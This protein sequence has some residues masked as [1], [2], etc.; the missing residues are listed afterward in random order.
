MSHK[1]ATLFPGWLKN[2]KTD[3]KNI[4][5]FI[6]HDFLLPNCFWLVFQTRYRVTSKLNNLFLFLTDFMSPSTKSLKNS[7]TRMPKTIDTIPIKRETPEKIMS[8]N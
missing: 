8:G 5:V 6:F 7:K 1:C 2:I 3:K 4:F